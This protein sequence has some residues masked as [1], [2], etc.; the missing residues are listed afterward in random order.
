MHTILVGHC[1]VRVYQRFT[2]SG[3]RV[4]NCVK[5]LKQLYSYEAGLC[6]SI[7]FCNNVRLSTL[8]EGGG[9]LTP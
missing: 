1:H 6:K 5:T 4:L 7:L 3:I 2:N 9:L 8:N